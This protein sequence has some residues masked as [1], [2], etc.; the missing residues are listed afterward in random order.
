VSLPGTAFVD[1]GA[2]VCRHLL[3]Y[4]FS[5]LGRID[6]GACPYSVRGIGRREAADA[7]ERLALPPP[8]TDVQLNVFWAPCCLS[9]FF[10]AKRTLGLSPSSQSVCAL[11]SCPGNLRCLVFSDT[12]SSICARYSLPFS[13]C[14]HTPPPRPPPFLL[15]L[16][17]L[18]FVPCLAHLNDDP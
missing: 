13:V 11:R 10:R 9:V 12:P 4:P 5:F 15:P 7:D 18:P 2:T 3:I 1:Q 16:A 6:L 8:P 17:F 14:I